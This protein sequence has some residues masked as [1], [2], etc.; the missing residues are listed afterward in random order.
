M[1]F[2]VFAEKNEIWHRYA[3]HSNECN[4]NL[5]HKTLT[6]DGECSYLKIPICNIE[7]DRKDQFFFGFKL[8]D[9]ITIDI[10][11]NIKVY[12]VLKHVIWF[13]NLLFLCYRL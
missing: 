12:N 8:C 4:E 1:Y 10:N 9:S 7:F 5:H 2:Q 11:Y 6:R 3:M 13:L